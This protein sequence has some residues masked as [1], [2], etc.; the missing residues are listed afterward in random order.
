MEKPL[1]TSLR[2]ADEIVEACGRPRVKLMM[3]HLLRFEVNYAMIESAIREG[4]IGRFLSAYARR[5]TPISESRRLRG[6]VVPA[7]RMGG[8]EQAG[9]LGRIRGRL[10]E[11]HRHGWSDQP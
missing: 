5:I 6:R 10:H 3:G 7:G 4:S 8:W 9:Q 1:A 11:C 2:D